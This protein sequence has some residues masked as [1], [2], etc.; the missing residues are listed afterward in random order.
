MLFRCNENG[1]YKKYENTGKN[2]TVKKVINHMMFLTYFVNRCGCCKRETKV[3]N[4]ATE[5][6]FLIR[7]I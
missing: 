4:N 3:G 6:E 2:Y 7:Q 1:K 5:T